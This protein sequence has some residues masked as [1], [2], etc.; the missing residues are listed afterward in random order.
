M[1][2]RRDIKDE[3]QKMR[4]G[5]IYLDGTSHQT[6]DSA[7]TPATPQ[8]LQHSRANT[9]SRNSHNTQHTKVKQ[10]SLCF[11]QK[12]TRPSQT[13]SEG[14]ITPNPTQNRFGCFFIAYGKYKLDY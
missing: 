12:D 1:L 6:G 5:N 10:S 4:I 13:C 7:F 2:H 14:L 11:L 8:Y 3:K 9:D